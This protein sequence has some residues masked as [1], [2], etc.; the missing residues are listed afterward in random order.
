MCKYSLS[1]PF[2]VS[3]TAA[4]RKNN[5]MNAEDSIQCII[6]LPLRRK[7]GQMFL[8]HRYQ[9]K[10][11]IY[12]W[13]KSYGIQYYRSYRSYKNC[14]SYKNLNSFAG[15]FRRIGFTGATNFIRRSMCLLQKQPLEGAPQNS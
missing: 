3:I 12:Q 5:R 2:R 13:L 15:I 1:T 11:M 14:K 10:T 8:K 7:T 9:H 6:E 4:K